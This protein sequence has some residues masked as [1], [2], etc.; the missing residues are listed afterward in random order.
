MHVDGQL[1]RPCVDHGLI[2]GHKVVV[3]GEARATWLLVAWRGHAREWRE[4]GACIRG[5]SWMRSPRTEHRGRVLP[6]VR[7]LV[8]VLH[9]LPRVRVRRHAERAEAEV[10]RRIPPRKPVDEGAHGSESC[11]GLQA[12]EVCAEAAALL[13]T[14]VGFRANFCLW[15]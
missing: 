12:V 3:C 7:S 10:A 9:L 1:S 2:L 13:P 6:R 8:E 11:R 14:E 5:W 15:R 4:D